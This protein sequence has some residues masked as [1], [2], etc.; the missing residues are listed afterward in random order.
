MGERLRVNEKAIAERV[1]GE[2]SQ[3][4][5]QHTQGVVEAAEVLAE[6]FGVDV[7]AARTAAW[8]HD[9]AREW[10]AEK[11]LQYA[12]RVEI[13]SGFALIPNILHGP[14][15]AAIAHEWFDVV[16]VDIAN[17]IRYHTTGRVAMSKLEMVLCL[18]DG[19]EV[20]RNY[21][22]VD[23]IRHWAELDLTHALAQ[24]FD[25]T[26]TYLLKRHEPIFPLTVMARNDLWERVKRME[27]VHDTILGG[28]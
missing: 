2:M 20:G 15:G 12:E 16:S 18:A 5:F 6:R 9:V 8:I 3:A 4:R 25:S 21:P 27:P 26:L 23:E 11:L 28:N 24:S 19:I 13:P 14:I 17:A 7:E 1:Q 22:G 10:P